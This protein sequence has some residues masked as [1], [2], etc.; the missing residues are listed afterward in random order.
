MILDIDYWNNW[1]REF[2]RREPVNV[3]ENF[4]LMDSMYHEALELGTLPILDPLEGLERAILYAKA[5]NVPT[6]SRPTV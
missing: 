4:R 1:E 5:I 6:P 2:Q 3:E